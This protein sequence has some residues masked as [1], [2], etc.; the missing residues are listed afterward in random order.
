MESIDT[1]SVQLGRN[2]E[3]NVSVSSALWF[4]LICG[5]GIVIGFWVSHFMR[6][7]DLLSNPDRFLF[8]LWATECPIVIL[9]F[10]VL[11]RDL[12]KCSY[13]RAV[14][15]G[16]LGLPAGALV[17]ALCAVALGAPVGKKYFLA[18][19]NWSL[20][21]A[22]FTVVPTAT[23]FGSS[24]VDWQRLFANTRPAGSIDYMLCVPAHGAILGSWFGAWP[25]PLDWE[26]PWQEWPICVACGG[27][28]GYMM[29]LCVSFG[30]IV[31][32]SR[33]RDHVKEE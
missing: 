3:R 11:R 20:L 31:C 19:V 17:I 8:I 27:V 29:G 14:G 15:R 5:L 33:R 23:V 25:M 22:L 6:S 32:S 18:T 2:V 28:A 7:I 30:L 24:F 21:M 9:M 12:S 26:R 1:K 4:H 16:L 10:A 13:L